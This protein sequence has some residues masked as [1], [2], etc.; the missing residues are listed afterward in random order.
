MAGGQAARAGT[1]EA[2]SHPAAAAAASASPA[3]SGAPRVPPR[4]TAE[5]LS[6]RLNARLGA[7][8]RVAADGSLLLQLPV[9]A[10]SAPARG[11]SSHARHGS[12]G[13]DRAAAVLHGPWA[14]DGPTGPSAWAR[15]SPDYAACARTGRQSPIDVRDPI[16]VQLDPIGFD[17]KPGGFSVVD[18][19]RTIQVDLAP[20]STIEVLGRR[21]ALQEFHFHRPSETRLNGRGFPLEAQLVHRDG[22]G[23]IAVVSVLFEEGTEPQPAVQA[24]WNNLPLERA[25]PQPAQ[26]P[27]DPAALLP[28]D[29]RYAEFMGSLTA[30]PCTEGV[31]WLVMT[32]PVPVTA[33]QLAIFARLYPM[34]A[35][36][37]Q[38]GGGRLIKQSQ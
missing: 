33:Q 30:P 36:P 15:L 13:H 27:L 37:L 21:Y 32:Q 29:R 2:A 19:G 10:A 17:Y 20:G 26:A 25:E 6:E 24:V 5:L 7:K 8:S 35:R 34:N 28:K 3:A 14:Y 31:L 18:T 4:D 11:A 12:G 38:A 1:G 16:L 23:R 9:S 22:E